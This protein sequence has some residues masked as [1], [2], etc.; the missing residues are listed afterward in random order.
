MAATAILR[1]P[2]FDELPGVWVLVAR[3]A[4]RGRLLERR[5]GEFLLALGGL[6]AIFTFHLCMRAD[7]REFGLG[8]VEARQFEP[9]LDGVTRLASGDTSVRKRLRH[10]VVERAAVRVFVARGAREVFE[11]IG[12]HFPRVTARIRCVALRA[13]YGEMR[14]SQREAALLMHGDRINRRLK[15]LY[16]VAAFA[17]S[18]V[19]SFREL[20]AVHVL[21]AIRAFRIPD[22][23]ARFLARR[24]VALVA[25]HACVLADQ[26]IGRLRMFLDAE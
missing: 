17:I 21:M 25:C 7:Q 5:F 26:R 10:L 13:G 3:T 4:P 15:S 9:G 12:N 1:L 8:V 24:D 20:A 14:A 6:V 23:V 19:G 22:L 11:V 18:V 16:D 2:G